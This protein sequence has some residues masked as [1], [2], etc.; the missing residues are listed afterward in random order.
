MLLKCYEYRL[1][2]CL[3]LDFGIN[4][5]YPPKFK[6]KFCGDK[7][8]DLTL[9]NNNFNFKKLWSRSDNFSN[10][11]KKNGISASIECNYKA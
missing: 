3:V 2:Y 1:F 7:S 10:W 11:L 5:S 6:S 4:V 8:I 9:S